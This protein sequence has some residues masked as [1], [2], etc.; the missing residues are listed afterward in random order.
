[1]EPIE[2]AVVLR[3]GAMDCTF[4]HATETSQRLPPVAIRLDRQPLVRPFEF[5]ISTNHGGIRQ[6]PAW[7]IRALVSPAQSESRSDGSHSKTHTRL[8]GQFD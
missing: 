4:P 3:H 5:R 7:D 8:L 2:V 1:M 6:K